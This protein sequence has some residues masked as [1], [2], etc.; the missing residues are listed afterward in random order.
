MGK[1][2]KGQRLGRGLGALLPAEDIQSASDTNADKLIGNV[3]ELPLDQITENP[4]QPRTV[5]SEE[6]LSELASSI[7]ELG[8]IQPITVRKIDTQKY[9]LISGERRW[10]AAKMAGLTSIPAFIRIANDEESL[11]MALVENIQ[12]QDLDPIEVALSYN[13]MIEELSLTQE[14]MSEKVGKKRSTITNYLRLLKLDPIIQTGIRDGFISMGHGRA[15]INIEDKEQQLELYNRIVAQ[16]L[17]VRDTEQAVQ[18]LKNP[19]KVAVIPPKQELKSKEAP[20]PLPSFVAERLEGL[21]Q[22][23]GKHFA[24]KIDKSGKGKIEIPFQTEEELERIQKIL[25]GEA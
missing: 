18:Q 13:R 25:H 22:R 24:V 6:A 8:V 4:Y 23:F 2:N 20:A 12:R 14:Q 17:S 19:Q 11:M 16:D 1:L 9:E 10:R 5:F 7:K 3:L 21:R 15:L